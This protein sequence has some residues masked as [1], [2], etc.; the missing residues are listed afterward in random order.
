M[1]DPGDT[2]RRGGSPAGPSSRL[3]AIESRVS[4]SS[5]NL[6]KG[7]ARFWKRPLPLNS[8]RPGPPIRTPETRGRNS[9]AGGTGFRCSSTL[10]PASSPTISRS[11]SEPPTR[12]STSTAKAWSAPSP[13]SSPSRSDESGRGEK[14][15]A[16]GFEA[17]EML[18][19]TPGDVRAIRPDQGRRHRRLRDHRGDAQATSFSAP[20]IGRQADPPAHRDL[21]ATLHHQRGEAR[22]AGVGA[23]GGR[24][25]GLSSSRNRWRPPS[26]RAS[27]SRPPTGNMVVDIGGGTTDV[28]VI[29]LSGIVTSSSIRTRWRQDGRGDHQLREAQVQHADRRALGRAGQDDRSRPR[30]HRRGATPSSDGDQGPRPRGRHPQGRGRDQRGDRRGA[31]G[32]HPQRSSRPCTSRSRRRR[33]SSPP[34]S[35]TAASCWWAAAHCCA[36]FDHVLRQ[37]TKLPILRSDDPFSA[38]VHGAGKALDNLSLLK[39]VALT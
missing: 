28:A 3:D 9:T 37:E 18:G 29:S 19:R 15:L 36:D 39:D 11:I 22:G 1:D 21:R 30:P 13:L 10:L 5:L 2:A 25:R 7:F 17:K 12:S 32:A 35:S 4:S 31:G 8:Q 38:V 14:V 27:T 23:L 33:P 26:V 16:V 20:T 6:L 24:A 34:T